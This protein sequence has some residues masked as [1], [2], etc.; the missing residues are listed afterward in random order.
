MRYIKEIELKQIIE[1]Y[2]KGTSLEEIA[3]KLNLPVRI[4]KSELLSYG[5]ENG[6]EILLKELE[7]NYPMIKEM[8]EDCKQGKTMEQFFER[9][10]ID[11]EKIYEA[12]RQYQLITGE[13]FSIRNKQGYGNSRQDLQVDKIIDQFRKGET[14]AKIAEEQEASVT[15][16]RSRI[17]QYIQKHG[18]EILEE[19]NKKNKTNKK[20][21]QYRIE[22]PIKEIVKKREQGKSCEELAK[23][24]DVSVPTIR[25]RIK[26]YKIQTGKKISSN[27]EK[28]KMEIKKSKKETKSEII[29]LS[30]IVNYFRLGYHLDQIQEFAKEKGWKINK[31]DLEIAQK[32]ERREIKIASKASIEKIIE[33]YGYS[34]EEL[35]KIAEKK[36]YKV[37]K[38]RYISA[39]MDINN[40]NEKGEER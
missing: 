11:I 26:E 4:I 2:E 15:A 20:V 32:I 27:I 13:K 7:R 18:N 1:E 22:L 5:R 10:H 12:I 9:Y 36:G 39:K 30:M 28:K 38:D 25:S 29:N 31:A 19:H 40:K 23:C 17:Q 16:V 35:T 14:L 33:K 3:K 8:A 24:Y 34:Y 37:L 21:K 6:K